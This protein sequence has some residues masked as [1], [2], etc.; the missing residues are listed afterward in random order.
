MSKTIKNIKFKKIN[1]SDKSDELDKTI[2]LKNSNELGKE[3]ENSVIKSN[4]VK[5]T[6]TTKK[7]STDKIN[8]DIELE[9]NAVQNPIETITDKNTPIKKEKKTSQRK[10][11]QKQM[12][13]HAIILLT[14]KYLNM[15]RKMSIYQNF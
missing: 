14:K 3:S 2:E 8:E 12:M 10:Q 1:K 6:K 11:F 9:K 13:K 7:K 5:I 4:N 15:K